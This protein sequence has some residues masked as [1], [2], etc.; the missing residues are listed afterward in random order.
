MTTE[1]P[2]ALAAFES[3][4]EEVTRALS[5]AEAARE[6]AR[7]KRVRLIAEMRSAGFTWTD[8]GRVLGVSQQRASKLG[9]SFGIS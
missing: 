7:K 1:A 5:R 8:V 2:P 6:D 9:Q 4:A 3:R